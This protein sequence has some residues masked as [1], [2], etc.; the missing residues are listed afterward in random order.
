M[1][2]LT[3]TIGMFKAAAIIGVSQQMQLGN[4]SGATADTNNHDH[5]LI[6]RTIEALDYNDNRG[7]PNWASWDLTAADAIG[8]VIRQDSYAPDTNLTSGFF[9][10]SDTAYA[11]SGCRKC[12]QRGAADHIARS[13]GIVI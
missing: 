5:Y 8:A 3:L 6:Q 1:V 12:R 2:V 10:V 7:A 9:H 13:D 4:P 11:H